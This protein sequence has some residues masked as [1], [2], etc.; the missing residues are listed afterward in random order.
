LRTDQQEYVVRPG[1]T[2]PPRTRNLE[3][4]F[5]AATLSIP[6]RVRFRYRLVGL[7]EGWRNAGA[8]RVAFYTNL[9][10]GDYRF[11]VLACNEDGVW[12]MT[13]ASFAF[14][15]AP[16]FVQT[17]WFKLLCALLALLLMALLYWRRMLAVTQRISERLRERLRERERIARALHDSFLQSVQALMMQFDLIK[18]SL[19]ADDP[20]HG[21]IEHA[22]TT[23]DDVLREG[24]EQ[25]LAL[26]LNHEQAG[27]LE[28]AL[29][30][31]G[32]ILGPR[33]QTGFALQ[34]SGVARPFRADAAA[35]AYAICREALQN[36]FRHAHSAQVRVE[37]RYE[38]SHFTL[39]VSDQGRGMD[40]A[41]YERGYRPG[42]F[43]LTGMRERAHDVGGTL[44]IDSTLGQGTTV[45]LLL[46]A[47]R[48]YAR[49]A[50]VPASPAAAP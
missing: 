9:E 11:E 20:L 3:L 43:G 44:E 18:H 42:H 4:D 47:R 22:L 8:R 2:L 37:L 50:T 6:E 36:A 46:P 17:I 41:V 28:T 38:R 23:A 39:R 25:V 45:T 5:T 13:P 21:R 26:R 24:R 27:D 31:L 40:A 19:G 35:E 34:V 49:A 12:G 1:L 7:E 15:I 48:A 32:H 10:P 16:T 29:S 30:G 14:R 33:Y